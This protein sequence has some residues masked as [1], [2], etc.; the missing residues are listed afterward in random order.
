M[1][2]LALGLSSWILRKFNIFNDDLCLGLLLISRAVQHIWW[3]PLPRLLFFSE[4]T[5]LMTTFAW[6][7]PLDF[8]KADTFND[9]LCLGF[10]SWFLRQF[11]ILNK[12]FCLGILLF[13]SQEAIY[14]M[15]TFLP[16]ASPLGFA[17]SLTYL[18]TTLAYLLLISRAFYIVNGD[19]CLGL[20]LLIY[21]AVQHI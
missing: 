21:L 10:S 6:V 4:Q 19:L 11:N 16:W 12:D 18:M 2:T 20:L 17:G 7:S 5:Y 3:Q 9:D 15:T 14:W 1:T 8:L 13:V